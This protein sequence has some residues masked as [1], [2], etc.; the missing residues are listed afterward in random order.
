MSTAHQNGK[1]SGIDASIWGLSDTELLAVIDDLA[2]EN[3]WTHTLDV[4]MQ[5]GEHPEEVG[6]RSGI[7]PRLGWMAR[8]GWLERHP[9]EPGTWRLTAMGHAI[10]DGADLSK[11][12]EKALAK[13][14][15]AQRIRLTREIGQAGAHSSAEIKTALRREWQRTLLRR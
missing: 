11:A 10:L 7:G 1:R 6:H 4:R 3:G 2:D 15:P 14:S 8:Y 12:F 9:D 13:L 5:L